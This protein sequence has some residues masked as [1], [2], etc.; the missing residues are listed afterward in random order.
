ML[1]VK[2]VFVESRREQICWAAGLIEGE[3]CFTLHSKNHPYFLLDL[4]DED[5]IDK[6]KE[7]FPFT[8]K[9]GPYENKKNTTNKPRWRIDAFG[10]LAYA[11]MVQVYPFLQSRRKAKIEE[12]IKIWSGK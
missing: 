5:T 6:L 10:P 8:T 3:G 1:L 2:E 4:T 12:L 7:I 9:R 11:L